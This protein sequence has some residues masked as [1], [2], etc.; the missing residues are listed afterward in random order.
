[1]INEFENFNPIFS[2]IYI[3]LDQRKSKEMKNYFLKTFTICFCLF[4]GL[5]SLSAQEYYPAE[6]AVT[7]ITQEYSEVNTLINE[8][9]GDKTMAYYK[10]V[11]KR[12]LLSEMIMGF[13]RGQTTQEVAEA[14]S[15]THS[16]DKAQKIKP[17]FPDSKGKVGTNWINEE[18]IILLIKD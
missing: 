5:T 1:M 6:E 2:T 13:K 3:L 9:S 16:K 12:Q 4:L 17:M 8:W 11:S 7:I 10:A 18:V 15:S 14:S